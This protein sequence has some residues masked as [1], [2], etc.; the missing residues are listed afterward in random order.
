MSRRVLLV[1][2]ELMFLTRIR[3]TARAAG[4]AVEAV[5]A[6]GAVTACRRERPDLVVFDLADPADPFAAAQAI[7]ADPDLA[8]I[9]LIGYYPHVDASLRERAV[10]AGIQP[11]P[12][13]A[14]TT[15]LAALLS[16]ATG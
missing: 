11:F 1:V 15:R 14:F 6:T 5:A 13:S 3:E 9:P 8:G 16:G 4:V 2:P 10:A 7:Q 12:R